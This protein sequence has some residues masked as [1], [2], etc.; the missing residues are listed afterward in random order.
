M[1]RL[2]N[3]AIQLVLAAIQAWDRLRLRRQAAKHPGLEI[4]PDASTNLAS[5]SFELQPGAHLRIGRGVVV[6][7]RPAGVRFI[8]ASGATLEIEED[9]W[10]HSDL[11]PVCLRLYA[12]AHM[13]I[14]RDSF[15]NSCMLSAKQEI[16]LGKGVLIGMGTR[17]FDSD[18]HPVD[19]ERG[20][21]FG[22]VH[23]GDH[24]W[25]AADV[26]VLRG[27][28]VGPH[29]VVA[30]RSLVRR[31]LPP[32]CLAMGVPAEPCAEV[33]DRSKIGF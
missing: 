14:G 15:L 5:A 30:A 27:V 13:R 31:S 12:G 19:A 25:L 26:T 2:K 11:G 4:H 22:P 18:Q 9:V 3:R 1:D 23:L 24:S 10:L 21:R 29:S 16:T 20:E 33:G 7:R 6:E 17:V 28:T 8:V 32:H